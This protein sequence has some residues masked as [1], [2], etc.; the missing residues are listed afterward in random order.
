MKRNF[1]YGIAVLA[2]AVVAAMNVNLSSK[3]HGMSDVSMKNFEA[4]AGIEFGTIGGSDYYCDMDCYNGG[5]CWK[6]GFGCSY[7]C[8]RSGEPSDWCFC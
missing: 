1:F 3:G 7:S 5:K 6:S 8:Y 4:L 2:I